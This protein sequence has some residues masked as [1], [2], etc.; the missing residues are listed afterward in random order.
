M[1][2]VMMIMVSLLT[3]PFLS[4]CVESLMCMRTL[5][6]QGRRVTLVI[7]LMRHQLLSAAHPGE[8]GAWAIIDQID[9]LYL[10]YKTYPYV[11]L[12]AHKRCALVAEERNLRCICKFFVPYCHATL[13]ISYHFS[14]LHIIVCC[15]FRCHGIC[16]W[17]EDK[18][19]SFSVL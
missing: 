11:T 13:N 9:G 7:P 1:M 3:P 15:L 8:K 2:M 18:R 19:N 10:T 14:S 16:T 6:I 4:F 12:G 17:K 5:T